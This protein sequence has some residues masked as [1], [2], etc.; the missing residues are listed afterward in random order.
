MRSLIKDI[1]FLLDL[2]ES[3]D[4]SEYILILLELQKIENKIKEIIGR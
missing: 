3:Y 2:L 4:K 1:D